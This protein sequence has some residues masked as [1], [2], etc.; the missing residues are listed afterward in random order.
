MFVLSL[1]S[2]SFEFSSEIIVKFFTVILSI[3]KLLVSK[4]NKVF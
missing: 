1:E 2:S 4:S 3:T